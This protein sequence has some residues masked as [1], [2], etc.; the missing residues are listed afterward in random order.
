VTISVTLRGFPPGD[1]RG[2]EPATRILRELGDVAAACGLRI[3]VYH[4]T[5]DWTASLPYALTIV[6]K[7]NHPQVG[8]NFSL[9]H[10]PA[11]WAQ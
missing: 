7:V 8:A 1:P 5:G 6:K 10:W 11:E 2:E 4:H 9:C 3:S